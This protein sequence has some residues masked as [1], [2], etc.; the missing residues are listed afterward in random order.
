MLSPFGPLVQDIGTSLTGLLGR[1]EEGDV[2]RDR[3]AIWNLALEQLSIS[4]WTGSDVLDL[5]SF[6]VNNVH[7][8]FLEV[9][10]SYGVLGLAALLL[11][12]M[13]AFRAA[14]TLGVPPDNL[15]AR[16]TAVLLL[17]AA[18][19]YGATHL[20]LVNNTFLWLAVMC[21]VQEPRRRVKSAS[22]TPRAHRGVGNDVVRDRR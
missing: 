1:P 4:P 2:S 12:L 9:A 6:G 8:A 21:L 16:N 11:L 17:W 18:V 14:F 19:V 3:Y 22:L 10:L 15:P 13:A 7:N 20:G 5:S